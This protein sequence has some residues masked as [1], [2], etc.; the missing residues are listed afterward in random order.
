M[1]KGEIDFIFSHGKEIIP[2]E[3]KSATRWQNIEINLLTKFIKEKRSPFG[4][5]LYRGELYI[6]YSLKI[7]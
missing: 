7:L 6:D 1:I 2:I 3:I 5:V 4:V